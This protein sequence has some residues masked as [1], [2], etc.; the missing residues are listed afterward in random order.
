MHDL[1]DDGLGLGVTSLSGNMKGFRT[2]G[3]YDFETIRHTL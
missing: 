2:I 1:Q 3:K